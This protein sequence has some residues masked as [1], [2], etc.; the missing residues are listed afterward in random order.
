MVARGDRWVPPRWRGWA[1][2]G[3]RSGGDGVR[4]DGAEQG[5]PAP[6]RGT[7]KRRSQM[8]RA[9]E[10][11]G[12]AGT[13]VSLKWHLWISRGEENRAVVSSAFAAQTCASG[14]LKKK[15]GRRSLQQE[16]CSK[17]LI[18]VSALQRCL[19]FGK[20]RGHAGHGALVVPR[21]EGDAHPESRCRVAFHLGGARGRPDGLR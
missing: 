14:I 11:Q 4:C 18:S 20:Q 1:G 8:S 12:Q 9:A 10:D 16:D 3:A 19:R 17:K 13:V 2:S 15:T 6:W 7:K 21:A 5:A